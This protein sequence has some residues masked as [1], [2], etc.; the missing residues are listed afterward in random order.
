MN[1]QD[2]NQSRVSSQGRRLNQQG[3][4]Q[5]LS[6][7]VTPILEKAQMLKEA[8][9]E[10][11]ELLK[12]LEED[13]NVTKED[14]E[15]FKKNALVHK[16]VLEVR[17]RAQAL[18][19]IRS[20]PTRYNKVDSKIAQNIQTQNRVSSTKQFNGELSVIGNSQTVYFDSKKYVV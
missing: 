10:Y 12:Q 4:N 13:E 2:L 9:L 18:Q 3:K 14:L 20:S 15:N 5:S 8:E 17:R 7:F 16:S 19:E 1:M 6:P 11:K